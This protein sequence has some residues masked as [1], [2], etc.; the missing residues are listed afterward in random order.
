MNFIRDEQGITACSC[1]VAWRRA[2]P[3]VV[4]PNPTASV[5]LIHNDRQST[6]YPNHLLKHVR[7]MKN[8]DILRHGHSQGSLKE[9]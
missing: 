2:Q 9:T 4:F 5:S 1:Y 8:K 3:G 7:A 6:M